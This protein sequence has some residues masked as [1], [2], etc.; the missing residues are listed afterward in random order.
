MFDTVL[1]SQYLE[2]HS[3]LF[4]LLYRNTV[5]HDI[6]GNDSLFTYAMNID[7]SIQC[8][9]LLV[10]RYDTNH[11]Q[12]SVSKQEPSIW[13]CSNPSCH[14]KHYSTIDRC[15]NCLMYRSIPNLH[16][17][18]LLHGFHVL[19]FLLLRFIFRLNQKI[20]GELQICCY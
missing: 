1:H 15:S 7:G 4:F 6:V 17:V 18:F 5:G 9:L 20:C 2:F 16:V 8:P 14:K 11:L 12:S 10:D 3:L 13:I 19:R